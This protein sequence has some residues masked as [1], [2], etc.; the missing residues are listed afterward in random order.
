MCHLSKRY[1]FCISHL[2]VDLTL[3]CSDKELTLETSALKL[4]V[5]F[6]LSTQLI[7]P[8]YFTLIGPSR[9]VFLYNLKTSTQ[10]GQVENRRLLEF[11]TVTSIFVTKFFINALYEKFSLSFFLGINRYPIS[12]LQKATDFKTSKNLCLECNFFSCRK[13]LNC[14]TSTILRCDPKILKMQKKHLTSFWKNQSLL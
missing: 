8:N 4:G 6:T 7:S 11:W 9:V 12:I 5:Q 3:I 2:C 14:Q 13:K 1:L 10:T